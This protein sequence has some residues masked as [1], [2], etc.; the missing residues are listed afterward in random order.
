MDNIPDINNINNTYEKAL[1]ELK[2]N[3]TDQNLSAW[4]TKYLGRKGILT[5]L[6]RNLKETPIDSRKEI[7]QRLN[8]IKSHLEKNYEEVVNSIG[9]SGSNNSSNNNFDI[10]MPGRPIQNGRLHPTTQMIREIC[11]AFISM[12]FDVAEGPEVEWEY[13]NFDALNIPSDHPARDMWDTLW[14]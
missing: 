1:E 14:V 7:G 13:Y 9:K 11:D 10:T 2:E 6:L 8:T 3:T 12:G 5:G 4:R